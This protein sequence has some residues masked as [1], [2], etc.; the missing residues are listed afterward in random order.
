MPVNS[1]RHIFLIAE[2]EPLIALDIEDILRRNGAQNL[3]FARSC[4]EIARHLEEGTRFYAA[5]LDIRLVDG[6]ALEVA[7]A[8][9]AGDTRLVFA[10]GDGSDLPADLARWPAITKPFGSAELETALAEALA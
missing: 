9:A 2:D 3:V 1:E 6:S 7:R 10:T 4:A 5:I 8:L